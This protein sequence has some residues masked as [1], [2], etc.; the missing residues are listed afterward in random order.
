[1]D[2]NKR[3]E[4]FEVPAEPGVDRGDTLHDSK[5]VILSFLLSPLISQKECYVYMKRRFIIAT[6]LVF[7]YPR[8]TFL[9]FYA[10]L[11]AKSARSFENAFY[12]CSMAL[13]FMFLKN[14]IFDE[15]RHFQPIEPR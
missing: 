3:T 1:M 9:E 13:S 4:L 7:D 10:H 8:R 2:Q 12:K 11:E 15:C 5:Q 14:R 6:L